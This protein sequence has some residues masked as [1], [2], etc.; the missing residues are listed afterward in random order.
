MLEDDLDGGAAEETVRFGI[1]GASYEID[2]SAKNARR[3]RK[4][5]A[6]FIENA[7]KAG[8]SRRAA[9]TTAGRQHS[10]DVR[11]WARAHGIAVSD[12]GRIPASV[13]EQFQAPVPHDTESMPGRSTSTAASGDVGL[14]ARLVKP[15]AVVC[16][17]TCARPEPD[18]FRPDSGV[19]VDPT[20]S[21]SFACSQCATVGMRLAA[22]HRRVWI[23]TI[24]GDLLRPS[25]PNSYSASG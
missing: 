5:L 11:A 8:R 14:A 4:Q 24:S 19:R 3:F 21:G 25:G 1:D 16:R 10:G 12:R 20:A 17:N 23:P 22:P 15:P 9:R 13:A 18:T 7:R 2:L 6:P